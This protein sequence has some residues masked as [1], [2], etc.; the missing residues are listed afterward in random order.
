MIIS[1][2]VCHYKRY[3]IKLLKGPIFF[4]V[5]SHLDSNG[6]EDEVDGGW[7]EWGAWTEC[8]ASCGPGTKSRSRT[9]SSPEPSP[10]GLPCSGEDS[11]TESCEKA[12]CEGKK[13][14]DNVI[15]YL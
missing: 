15:S 5:L 7:S 2:A 6:G 12:G 4:F 13:N 14:Q 3:K 10:N 9:C 11:E 8:T 1:Y